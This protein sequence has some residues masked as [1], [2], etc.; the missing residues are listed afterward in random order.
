MPLL[1]CGIGSRQ[2]G[3]GFAKPE[4]ELPE[5][6]LALAHAQ[7]DVIGLLDPSRQRLAIPQVHAHSRVARLRP[8]YAIDFL[9]LLFIQ[10]ARAP[11]PFSLRQT[12]QALF[13][14]LVGEIC[15]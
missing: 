4:F 13:L 2:N 14:G 5:Q 8:Q 1:P 10:A 7:F 6:A 15:G 11:G 12:A 9:D 3:A